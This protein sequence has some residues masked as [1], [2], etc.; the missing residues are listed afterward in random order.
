[1]PLTYLEKWVSNS[2][3]NLFGYKNINF[4]NC[5]LKGK[6]CGNKLEAQKKFNEG[7]KILLE[8]IGTLPI[9]FYKFIICR[10]EY[11]EGLEVN[12]RGNVIL[13]KAYILDKNKTSH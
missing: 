2:K 5:I 12:S 10:K 11:I 3:Q 9:G 13:K 4:D 6:V 1:M 8:D 7:E